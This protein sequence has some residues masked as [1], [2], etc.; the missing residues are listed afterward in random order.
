MRLLLQ[1]LFANARRLSSF[2]AARGIK[3]LMLQIP[4][5]H[6]GH[7]SSAMSGLEQLETLWLA[8]NV[9]L[10]CQPQTSGAL[11]LSALRVCGAWR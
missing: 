4:N 5:P 2:G 3:H 7:L 6:C 1:V 11:Q 8:D 9:G 10:R